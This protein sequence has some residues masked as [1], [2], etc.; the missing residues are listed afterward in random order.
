[1]QTL[2]RKEVDNRKCHKT[3][4]KRHKYPRDGCLC[5]SATTLY[6]N[7]VKSATFTTKYIKKNGDSVLYQ[8]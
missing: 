8:K 1:M 7:N 2:F 6:V 3:P 5:L 4:A